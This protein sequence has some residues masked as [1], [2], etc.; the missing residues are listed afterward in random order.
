MRL[1]YDFSWT[2][3]KTLFT[4]RCNRTERWTRAKNQDERR[5]LSLHLHN[6]FSPTF[7]LLLRPSNISSFHCFQC[8]YN[9]NKVLTSHW[10]WQVCWWPHVCLIIIQVGRYYVHFQ[11]DF[12][13]IISFPLLFHRISC[14]H[15]SSI[16]VITCLPNVS[17]CIPLSRLHSQ[18][19]HPLCFFIP[20]SMYLVSLH[21]LASTFK[22][23]LLWVQP[24]TGSGYWF[25]Y[26]AHHFLYSMY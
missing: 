14:F 11:P 9:G 16:C 26:L 25:L 7:F 13:S 4:P 17:Q 23:M 2:W 3:L 19:T 24:A 10:R 8:L 6:Y 18:P 20:A 22:Y 5:A 15:F 1:I 12:F 21:H